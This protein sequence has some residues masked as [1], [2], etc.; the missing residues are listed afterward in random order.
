LIPTRTPVI[1]RFTVLLAL[2][3]VIVIGCGGGAAEPN[4]HSAQTT[5]GVRWLGGSRPIAGLNQRTVG[6][7]AGAATLLWNKGKPPPRDAVVFLHG[8]L[9]LPPVVY[10]GW[11]RHLARQGNTIVYPFY[12]NLRA[13]P[14]TFRAAA[15]EGISAG[16]HAAAADPDSVV[17]I[18]HTTGGALAFDYAAVAAGQGLPQPRAVFAVYPGRNPPT[19]EIPAADLSGI[20]PRTLLEVVAGPGDPIP[21]GGAEAHALLDGATRVPATGKTYLSAPRRGHDPSRQESVAPRRAFW[22]PADRLIAR[23]RRQDGS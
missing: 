5:S 8:W 11:V 18:G 6:H 4:P 2:A 20:R 12:Q 15:L 10:R 22:A 19:G 16:L 1:V 9:P 14:E 21:N 7:G 23:A 13:K 17:A 3:A